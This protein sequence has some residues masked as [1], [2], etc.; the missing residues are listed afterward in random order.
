MPATDYTHTNNPRSIHL[1]E[2]SRPFPEWIKGQP[3]PCREG[4]EKLAAQAFA[5]RDRKL[6]PVHE[7]VSAFFS[8][9]DYFANADRYPDT[10][11]DRIKEACH[12]FGIGED[13]APYAE[14][15]AARFEKKA[16]GPTEEV[17]GRFAINTQINGQDFQLLPLNDAYEI[18]KAASD[19]R[20]MVTEGRIHYLM[21]VDASRE[22]VKAASESDAPT[23]VTP[24]IMVVGELRCPDL[25]KA[26]QLIE[27]RRS[28]VAAHE[29]AYAAYL[30]AIKEASDGTITA[31]EC[32][33]KIA[34]IDDALHVNYRYT[35]RARVPLPH[36]I[37]FSGPTVADVEKAA[38]SNVMIRDIFVPIT[39]VRDLPAVDIEFHL[40]KEAAT[41]LLA[42]RGECA[43]PLSYAIQ[44]WSDSDQKALLRRLSQPSA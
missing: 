15:F 43:K 30:G 38:S 21:F 33:Q 35:S 7:K 44:K 3:V 27:S 42:L 6:L 24:L 16:S 37:V 10:T 2:M 19:L 11:F 1:A 18:T 13:V 20:T 40:E 9:I 32:M 28:V 31:D 12:Y 22:I 39:A 36:T 14:V 41:E 8:A 34:A 25:E 5:D 26:A 4:M 29:G 23:S 17:V